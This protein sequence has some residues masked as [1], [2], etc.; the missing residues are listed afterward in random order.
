MYTDVFISLTTMAIVKTGFFFLKNGKKKEKL[1][2]ACGGKIYRESC[3]ELSMCVLCYVL[4][5]KG[6]TVI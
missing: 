1:N 3:V 2:K 4:T 5:V 6:G